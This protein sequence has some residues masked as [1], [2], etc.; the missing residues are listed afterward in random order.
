MSWN[1]PLLLVLAVAVCGALALIDL[2]VLAPR[3]RKAIQ[4]Y[5]QQVSE[6]DPAVLEQLNKEPA[7]VE[8][9]KAFFPVL[10]IALVLRSFLVGPFQIPS[11]SACR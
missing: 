6:P 10:P 2:L 4:T 1:F 8:Y 11:A 5:G 9:G 3:R 7:L